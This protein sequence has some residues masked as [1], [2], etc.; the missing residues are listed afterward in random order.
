MHED[1]LAS[2]ASNSGKSS[3][4]SA[5]ATSRSDSAGKQVTFVDWGASPDSKQ[6]RAP[7]R[8]VGSKQGA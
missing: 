5:V 8:Q 1:S 2:R 6:L 4:G 7:A 3:D